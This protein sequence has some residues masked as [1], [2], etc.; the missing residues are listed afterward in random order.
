[1]LACW[2]AA[3]LLIIAPIALPHFNIP[4]TIAVRKYVQAQR[5]VCAAPSEKGAKKRIEWNNV[6]LRS[7]LDSLAR[8]FA[9]SPVL[10][11][12]LE[13]Q[14]L[15]DLGVVVLVLPVEHR[16]GHLPGVG[17]ANWRRNVDTAPSGKMSEPNKLR[18]LV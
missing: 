10:L 2:R 17:V 9:R 13:V 4:I 18:G 12:D 15:R 8:H 14:R 7:R 6:S 16:V 1:M 3:L 5:G 11:H